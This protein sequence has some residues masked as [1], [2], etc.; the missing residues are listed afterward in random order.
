MNKLQ[1]VMEKYF[2]PFAMKIAQQRHLSAVK[3]GLIASSPLIIVGSFFLVIAYLPLFGFGG[4]E[5][6]SEL[7]GPVWTDYLTVP[8][9]GSFRL[10]GLFAA[11]SV[12]FKLA[13]SYKVDPIT[14][15]L[16]SLSSYFILIPRIGGSVSTNFLD[17][18]GVFVAI[19]VSI[20]TGEVYRYCIQNDIRVKMPD[21]CPPAVVKAFSGL[22]PAMF[23][24]T[25]A[26][27]IHIL[28][29][30][31]EAGTVHDLVKT[32]IA[33]PLS[34]LATSAVGGVFYVLINSFF[35]SMGIHGGS[36][37][38]MIFRPTYLDV[39]AQNIE[40]FEKGLEIPH[41]I[42]L[43]MLNTFVFMGGSGVTFC[44][45]G[46]FLF[47][48]K[49]KRYKEMGKLSSGATLFNINEPVIFGT[50]IVLN[51]V[52]MIPF[53]VAPLAVFTTT[54]ITMK[55]GLVAPAVLP[56][57]WTTP[58]VISGF[59]ATGGDFKASILQIFNI[60]LGCAIYLPF[61]KAL[62]REELKEEQKIEAAKEVRV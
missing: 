30:Q 40:A 49:S 10:I 41:I 50:P 25:G 23:T 47:T 6:M 34:F 12:A 11:F 20:A 8:L 22:I 4:Y 45:V 37:A 27:V 16:L 52:M 9:M 26:L 5:Y 35:W 33:T 62:E 51:P 17:G 7:I 56:I 60:A 3:D 31:T 2:M 39:M 28:A 59:L 18:Q 29:A 57:P 21:T 1:G 32:V 13:E 38:N 58:P 19:L 14:G 53:I 36:I 46:L 43:E 44:L 61:V 15:G 48:A 55:V 24:I 42:S 54:V